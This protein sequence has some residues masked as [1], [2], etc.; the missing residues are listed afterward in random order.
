MM[1]CEKLGQEALLG[2]EGASQKTGS[3]VRVSGFVSRAQTAQVGVAAEHKACSQEW[4]AWPRAVQ[5][6]SK[7]E[8]QCPE[9]AGVVKRD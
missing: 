6:F 9:E 8:S 2:S 4:L 5:I 3:I 1:G 7:A